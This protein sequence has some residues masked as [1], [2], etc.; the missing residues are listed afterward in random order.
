[1]KLSQPITLQKPPETDAKGNRLEH[2]PFTVDELNPVFQINLQHNYVSVF[3]E[4]K[5]PAERIEGNMIV[6]SG[7]QFTDDSVFT[8]SQLQIKL[9]EKLGDDPQATLQGL[10]PKTVEQDPDG[11]G[12]ILT[13]M[14]KSIGIVSSSSCSCRRHA[15]EMN[16]KG[17]DWC[18]E[19]MST[20]LGWLKDESKKR[21]LPFV[22]TVAK[23][24]VNRAISKSRKLKAQ[25]TAT[26]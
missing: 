1:M 16:E 6:V 14:I 19:N 12:A 25:K 2:A 10:F 15:I 9:L 21:N 11:P 24:I 18:E 17:S 13:N 26:A 8:P 22:E 3:F 23:M 5:S 20:I 4:A 7:N